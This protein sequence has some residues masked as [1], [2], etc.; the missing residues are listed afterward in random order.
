MPELEK[1][2]KFGLEEGGRVADRASTRLSGLR[3]HNQALNSERRDILN[4]LV[5]R[6]AQILQ[7]TIVSQRQGRPVLALKAAAAVQIPGLIHDSSASGS[8]V[9]LEPQCVITLGNRIAE[10]SSHIHEEEQLILS[11]GVGQ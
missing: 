9:F 10:I 2:L 6:Y 1:I 7:D 3:R 5:R 8:T 11:N 4:D